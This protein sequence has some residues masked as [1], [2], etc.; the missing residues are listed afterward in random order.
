MGFLK[1]ECGRSYKFFKCINSDEYYEVVERSGYVVGSCSND[2]HFY[3][4]CGTRYQGKITNGK[5]LCENFLCEVRPAY[6]MFT[7]LPDMMKT[8]AC[9]GI[10]DCLNTDLDEEED[11]CADLESRKR[12]TNCDNVCS[13]A[14]QQQYFTCPDEANCNGFM[15]GLYCIVVSPGNG[16]EYLH[17]IN[18]YDICD[19]YPE[20][21]EGEDEEN[22]SVDTTSTESTV[23][24]CKRTEGGLEVRIFNH[25]RCTVLVFG[26]QIDGSYCANYHDQT[27]CTDPA[28]VGGVCEVGGFTT[29]LSLYI[30]CHF[31]R[32]NP[33]DERRLCDDGLESQC[34][35]MSASCFEHKHK[36]CDG[37]FDC[38]DE[39]DENNLNCKASAMTEKTC[40]RKIGRAGALPIPLIW[41]HDGIED[42]VDGVDEKQEWPECGRPGTSTGR[43]VKNNDTCQNV[44]LCK[45]SEKEGYVNYELLCDGIDTCGT[46][47][48]NKVCSIARNVPELQLDAIKVDEEEGTVIISPLCVQGLRRFR[49][50]FNQ[51]CVYEHFIYPTDHIFGFN[52][53]TKILLP[54]VE[55]NC[56]HLFGVPYLYTSCTGRCEDSSCPLTNVPRY[57]FCPNQYP[58]RI[59]TL[60]DNSYLTFLIKTRDGQYSNSIFVCHNNATC[61]DYDKV[62]NLV[63]DC[64]DGSDE[65]GC[66][67][68]FQCR[69]S[70]DTRLYIPLVKTCDGKFDCPD[71]S[72]ECNDRCDKKILESSF[73]KAMSVGIGGAAIFTN[74]YIVVKQLLNLKSCRTSVALINKLLVV[75]IAVGDFLVGGYLFAIS[76]IDFALYG[77]QYCPNQTRWLSSTEC[78]LI[79]VLSTIGSQLSLFSMTGLS[80]V[81]MH[82]ICTSM[83][84]PGEV[85]TSK[86]ISILSAIASIV[87]VSSAI[88]V[89]PVI[90]RYEDFFVNG[91]RYPEQLR[92]FIGLTDKSTAFDVIKAYNGRVRNKVL[93][94]KTTNKMIG[95]MFSRDPGHQDLMSERARV[96]F[97]GND[98]VCL[99]KYFVQ[100]DDPQ[101]SFVWGILALNF[102]CFV[103]ISICYIAIGIA[104]SRSS[105]DLTRGNSQVQKRN[106]RMNRKI[107][108]I[109]TTDFLCWVPFIVI[110]GLHFGEVLDAT[111]WYS[112]F[113][114]IILPINSVINPLLYD[115]LVTSLLNKPTQAGRTF[116]TRIS[117]RLSNSITR[118]TRRTSPAVENSQMDTTVR[119]QTTD[120]QVTPAS[121]Q[122]GGGEILVE[123]R[124]KHA[125]PGKT[126]TRTT[127]T[128][129]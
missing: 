18:V 23:P 116:I 77:N 15:Y 34:F 56:D 45:N 110:C 80:L 54:E 48:E 84:I 74:A 2:P 100:Q 25:T 17:Y 40:K 43:F 41:L 112:L 113:S 36:M 44:F 89:I 65:E 123:I 5:L 129:L 51:L 16:R 1:T 64:G 58:N 7:H 85:T 21:K 92:I 109:I 13:D 52:E 35:Q 3:M 81:R 101:L 38:P 60:V 114:I 94:W 99:F 95:D 57:E 39:S 87:A 33:A 97:Y 62:C 120:F 125:K 70:G 88:A 4:T 31:P 49:M 117:T 69:N 19:G 12:V 121:Q 8:S 11:L 111:Q 96:G 115:D 127:D 105:K 126:G 61:I 10:K 107:A 30:I 47:S 76:I 102:F 79:G 91:V 67:N 63:D 118:R 104:S 86:S 53:K 71:L 106:N 59:G 22:C 128:R 28:R 78:S 32:I 90:E 66:T 20:C 55:K 124:D 9:N 6:A 68:H 42:C 24:T 108:I 14:L 119:T 46:G 98:G 27:N 93:S 37:I 72:D 103:I 73:L 26:H 82:G 83:R 122:A 50:R 75:L 29:N